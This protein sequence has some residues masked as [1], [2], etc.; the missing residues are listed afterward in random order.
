VKLHDKPRLRPVADR[1]TLAASDCP[2]MW[3]AS[4]PRTSVTAPHGGIY[5]VE[6]FATFLFVIP[7]K[8]DVIIDSSAVFCTGADKN[9]SIE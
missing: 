7:R 8:V 3:N 5:N 2:A 6:F 1:S 9:G 4:K